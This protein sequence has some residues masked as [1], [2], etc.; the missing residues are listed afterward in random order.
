MHFTRSKYMAFGSSFTKY[1]C[2]I[3]VCLSARKKSVTTECK[4]IKCGFG[5]F[6]LMSIKR[7][8]RYGLKRAR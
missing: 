7:D 2:Y 4:F 1:S 5:G 3:Y 6:W 8:G